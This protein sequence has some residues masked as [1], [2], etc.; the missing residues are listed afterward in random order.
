MLRLLLRIAL[1]VLALQLLAALL[2]TVFA[3]GG[4]WKGVLAAGALLAALNLI[5]R[6]LL[7][8]ITFPLRLFSHLVVLILV[9][10]VLLWLATI[11]INVFPPTLV[12]F[13]IG[14][15]VWGWIVAAGTFGLVSWVIPLV[16][17]KEIDE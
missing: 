5:A 6:P 16:V 10:A 8:L 12:T 7:T 9:N 15:G 3:V 17:K 13:S 1:T 11:L 2:P 4:G 14:N